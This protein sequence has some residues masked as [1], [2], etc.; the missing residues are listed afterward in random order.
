MDVYLYVYIYIS[1]YI[2][3]YIYIIILIANLNKYK[4]VKSHKKI[5]TNLDCIF[6][7]RYPTEDLVKRPQKELGLY[8][9][10][11]CRPRYALGV[12]QRVHNHHKSG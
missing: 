10:D 1:I 2:I 4:I 7:G 11:S 9:I 6:W 8:G 12:S 5:V 3:I